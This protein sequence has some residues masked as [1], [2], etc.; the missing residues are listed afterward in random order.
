MI[1]INNHLHMRTEYLN[2]LST[3]LLKIDHLYDHL[4]TCHRGKNDIVIQKL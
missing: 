1:N 4:Q 2:Y 3:H